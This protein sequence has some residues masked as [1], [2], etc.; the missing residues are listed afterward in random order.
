MY[1]FETL[2][3]ALLPVGH[4]S[5]INYYFCPTLS[6]GGACIV[7]QQ[8]TFETNI[9]TKNVLRDKIRIII[10]STFETSHIA[11]AEYVEYTIIMSY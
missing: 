2:L 9:R 6:T 8:I 5:R 3:I 10:L 7:T 4:I 1:V 11:L